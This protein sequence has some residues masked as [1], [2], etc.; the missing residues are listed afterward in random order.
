MPAL[1]NVG[2]ECDPCGRPLNVIVQNKNR[3]DILVFQSKFG[4]KI[5]MFHCIFFIITNAQ[6]P[7]E[8]GPDCVKSVHSSEVT[9]TAHVHTSEYRAFHRTFFFCVKNNA[10]KNLQQKDRKIETSEPL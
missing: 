9:L 6:I 2:P 4:W 3:T 10:N 8:C 1:A 5:E 7:H